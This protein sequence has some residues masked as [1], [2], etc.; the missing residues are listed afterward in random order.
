MTRTEISPI[1]RKTAAVATTMSVT[2]LLVVACGGGGDGASGTGPVPSA[3]SA[4]GTLAI[5]TDS[6]STFVVP[7]AGVTEY[8]K[9]LQ[10]ATANAGGASPVNDAPPNGSAALYDATSLRRQWCYNAENTAAPPELQ[11]RAIIA[12]VQVFE[13]IW[14]FGPR[15]VLQYAFKADNGKVFLIDALNNTGEAQAI[16]EPGL[17][18][19]GASGSL[20]EGVMPTHG[21][22]DH[23]GGAGY[24]Q[25]KYGIPVYLGSADAGVGA[26]ATPPFVVTPLDS[27]N[28]QPQSRDFGGLK[29][30]LLS[31]PGHTAG[32][33]SGIVPAKLAGKEYRLAFWGGT[34]FPGTLALARSYLDGSERLY[35]LAAAEKIDGTFHTHPFV[36]GSLGKLDALTKNPPSYATANP[37]LIGKALAMRSLSVLRECSAAK[38]AQLDATAKITP[39]HTTSLQASGTTRRYPGGVEVDVSAVV[40]NPYGA[41]QNAAVKFT[42]ASTGATCTS[43]TDASGKASCLILVASSAAGSVSAEFAEGTLVDGSVELASSA[44]VQLQ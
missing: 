19:M 6:S 40:R 43:Y 33:F 17:V 24:L 21:H 25:A 12:P 11:D 20:L 34:A 16:T 23:Y 26:T 9:H 13:N 38:V 4:K 2:T 39:W 14:A 7:A 5:V 15:W 32:T 28:L 18:R 42:V 10:I 41:L 29:T 37:F 36:D 35:R 44:T 3:A 27:S 1:R 8:Q 31:T 30:T 22:G